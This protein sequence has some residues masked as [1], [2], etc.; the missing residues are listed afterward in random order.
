VSELTKEGRTPLSLAAWRNNAAMVE[1]LLKLDGID[2]SHQDEAGNTAL[3]VAA[4]RG[5]ADVVKALL[6]DPRINLHRRN[7]EGESA[8][9]CALRGGSS[10][11][12]TEA[13]LHLI[14]MGID[15]NADDRWGRT[16]LML[17][18]DHPLRLLDNLVQHPD[19][20]LLK[21][22]NNGQ[23]PLMHACRWGRSFA[24]Q[25]YLKL[26]GVDAKDHLEASAL[27]HRAQQREMRT[28]YEDHVSDF[29]A[30]VD[31][32]LDVNAKDAEGFTALTYAVRDGRTK[33]ARALLQ[34]EGVDANTEDG[35]GRT[36]LM[37]ACDT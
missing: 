13:A 4:K 2:V 21:R 22:D 16:P 27:I 28:T 32:G 17:A 19:I 12:H 14:A 23:T 34:L 5:S 29:R 10:S 9:H 24:L 11:S 3:L 37:V 6:L 7:K 20:D 8:L 26:P 35:E 25:W 36:L 33:I 1:L 15:V 30:L 31:A 18:Y